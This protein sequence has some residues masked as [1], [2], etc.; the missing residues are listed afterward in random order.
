MK[1]VLNGKKRHVSNRPTLRALLTECGL[2][3][4]QKGV[5]VAVNAEIVTR[6]EWASTRVEAGDRIDIIH[7]V[8]GG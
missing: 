5:A 4:S 2:D 8:Q 3:P 6:E 1:I 7:A